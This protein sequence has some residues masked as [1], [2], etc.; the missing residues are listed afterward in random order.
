MGVP[1]FKCNPLHW[2]AGWASEHV[3]VVLLGCRVRAHLSGV[4]EAVPPVA[5]EM[6]DL[7]KE[8][9]GPTDIQALP[10]P[11]HSLGLHLHPLTCTS[12]RFHARACC[13]QVYAG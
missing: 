8:S 11:L 2:V 5:L 6:V 4:K 7:N 12:G 13:M 1:T 3:T 9:A 10:C